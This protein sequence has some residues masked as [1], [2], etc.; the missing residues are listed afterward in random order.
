MPHNTFYT[1]L[2]SGA[3]SIVCGVLVSTAAVSLKERQEA[4]ATLEKRN[5]VLQAAGLTEPGEN[6]PAEEVEELFSTIET[7]VVELQTGEAVSDVDAETFDQQ[8]EASDPATSREAPENSA[9]VSRVPHRALVYEVR[10]PEGRLEMIILPV[11]GYGLW[12]TLYGFLALDADLNTIRGLTFY[13]HGE[14]PGLGGEVDNPGWKALWPKRKVFD[15]DGRPRI[16]VIKG[17]AR[18]P[19]L[20]PYKVDGLTGASITSRGVTHLIHF[21]L[22]EN[23]FGPYLEKVRNRANGRGA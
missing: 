8:D 14:T 17:K 13:Q 23:G 10:D 11:E 3:I 7:V 21:W 18:E 12:S 19:E 15:E 9:G 1:V 22:G 5:N 16:T 6:L 20:D 4:N 2:F